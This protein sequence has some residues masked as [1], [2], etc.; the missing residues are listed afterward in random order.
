M[1]KR[2]SADFRVGDL[3]VYPAHGVG[4]IVSIREEELYGARAE[5]IVITIEQE[6][7]RL[8]VPTGRVAPSGL[9]RLADRTLAERALGVLAGR[10]KGKS[11]TWPRRAQE[12]ER[13]IRSGD[14]LLAAE[15]V[16]DLRAGS[17]S[18]SYSERQIY[19][20]ALD[21]VV[22]EVGPVL[23]RDPEL[24]RR[25]LEPPGDRKAA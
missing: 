8:M 5:M 13:K 12:Y 2:D 9:R 1:S 25:E 11:G 6:G 3:I 22:R 18:G 4:R 17:G 14:L 23:G 16:R 10:P 24:L 21:R 7:L 15:V 20:R 19:E